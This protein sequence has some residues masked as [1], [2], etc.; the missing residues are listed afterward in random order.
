VR[1]AEGA[2]EACLPVTDPPATGPVR[3]PTC[4][5]GGDEIDPWTV[6]G[7][8]GPGLEALAAIS[9]DPEERRWA[10][11]DVNSVPVLRWDGDVRVARPGAVARRLSVRVPVDLNRAH[12]MERAFGYDVDRAVIRYRTDEELASKRASLDAVLG[13]H[14]VVRRRA[15]EGDVLS[16]DYEWMIE[17]SLEDVRPVARAILS[18]ARRRGARGLREEFGAFASFVQQL[19]YGESPA[20]D[21]GKHRFGLS[22]PAWALATDTGDC[23]T[24]AVLLAA[25]ARSVRLC[26]VHLVRDAG[27]AHMLAAAEIPVQ[28][29]DAIVRAGER[30]LVLV[31]TT[32]EWPVGRVPEQTRGASLQTLYL[33]GSERLSRGAGRP[34]SPGP[35][36]IAMRAPL[37]APA[38]RTSARPM[39]AR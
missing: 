32:D 36:P 19:R 35:R 9:P 20:V 24:R 5:G 13:A 7:A 39:P 14:G 15:G 10:W 31:E 6:D 27:H 30:T 12:A 23:D 29:G 11:E 21:D 18:E 37:P 26:E 8:H 16:P 4:R 1:D 33:D 2:L 34:G 17:A 25:L 22:M 38:P 28:R 3:L